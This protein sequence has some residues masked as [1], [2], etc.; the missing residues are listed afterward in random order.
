MIQ[1]F[2][3]RMRSTVVECPRDRIE[4]SSGE[5]ET[6]SLQQSTAVTAESED[7][8]DNF[9]KELEEA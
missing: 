7:K 6:I 2:F 8:N 5:K 9:L 3:L 1:I 4:S